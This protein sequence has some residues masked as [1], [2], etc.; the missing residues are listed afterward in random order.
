MHAPINYSPVRIRAA[1]RPYIV[2]TLIWG[3]L[4]LM[5]LIAVLVGT[6][7]GAWK[8]VAICVFVLVSGFFWI[9]R[10]QITL[11]DE[12]IS[13]TSLFSRTASLALSEIKRA[14]FARGWSTYWDQLRCRP[15]HSLVI[16][17]EP[18]T[19]KTSVIINLTVFSQEDV[20]RVIRFLGPKLVRGDR[21]LT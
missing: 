13:Y 15:L 19:G 14:R 20:K 3:G 17:P 12:C 5:W 21:G 1:T 16:E 2:F 8:A 18:T 7:A 9:G 4:L 10:F 6:L 11:S